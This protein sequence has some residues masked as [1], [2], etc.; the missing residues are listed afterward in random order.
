MATHAERHVGLRV[1]PRP[2]TPALHR[3]PPLARGERVLITEQDSSDGGGPIVA[4]SR[5]LYHHA[6]GW[7]LPWE[8]LGRVRWTP[9]EGRLE[10]TRFGAPP[11]LLRIPSAS[12]LPRIIRD[13]VGATE[14][15]G[16]RVAM[17]DGR[18]ATVSARRRPG[19]GETIWVVQLP[20]GTDPG[21]PGTEA[22]VDAA[23]R[24]LRPLLP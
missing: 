20:D 24:E 5:A 13:L 14:L 11:T 9:A 1:L 3:R 22:R 2:A 18:A 21:D 6:G 16:T 4:T 15:I 19:T 12:R 8:E 17:V 10:L 23:I 7:R